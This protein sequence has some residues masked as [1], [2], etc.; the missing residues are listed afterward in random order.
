MQTVHTKPATV[1]RGPIVFVAGLLL[2]ASLALFFDDALAR[3]SFQNSTLIPLDGEE[4]LA[5]PSQEF[6][7][8]DMIAAQTA[9]TYL[10]A[11]THPETGF[12]NS[13]D[14]Y[15]STTMWDQGSYLLGLVSAV[16][17]GLVSEEAF[18]ARITKLLKALESL[19]LFDGRLPNKAYNT[20]TLAMVNYGNQ[21]VDGG[22]GWS[23]L[24]MGRF[25]MA[26]RVVEKHYP[27]HGQQIRAILTS[28]DLTAMAAQGE[29]WGSE[30]DGNGGYV[31]VQEGRIGYEQYAARA[32]A[33]WGLDV[34]RAASAER[35][36]SW[37][38]VQ[39]QQ[40]PTDLRRARSF[41]AITPVLSEPYVLIGLEFGFDAESATL[42]RSI[43]SA[44]ERRHQE[45]GL[46][47]MVS[48]DHIDQAP[49]FLYASVFANGRP[50]GVV[51]ED[52]TFHDDLRTQSTKASFAWH[53]LMPSDYTAMA[54]E[55]VMATADPDK[56]FPAGLYETDGTINEIYT[57]NT[58][59]I[60]LQALH[61][62]K[63]G[64]LW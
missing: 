28:W 23:A 33:L 44:Q 14:G 7:H 8:A 37:T 52:G 36:V 18:E 63:F 13:V 2:S 24:D 11:N 40:V 4:P 5:G 9:W 22:I 61:Y 1:P 41:G 56:G 12:V 15:P 32:A 48:E 54:R 39:G 27:H 3:L 17:L 59:A 10:A 53:A 58:N 60:V 26:L 43:L 51:T 55:R 62:Q 25:L 31:R 46:V 20:Q 30:L 19:P 35:V 50:W 57:L 49:H 29:L 42:A 16:R 64:P 38:E 34:L 21:D 45:T 47:T 6:S